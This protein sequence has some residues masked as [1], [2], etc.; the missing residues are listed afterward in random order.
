MLK[1]SQTLS[2]YFY[3]TKLSVNVSYYLYSIF[4]LLSAKMKFSKLLRPHLLL[5]GSLKYR[6]LWNWNFTRFIC[7]TSTSL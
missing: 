1:M 3:Y 4:V 5:T 6:I 2:K 7:H